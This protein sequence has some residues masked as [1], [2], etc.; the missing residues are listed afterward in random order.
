MGK[1]TTEAQ[2]TQRWGSERQVS[3]LGIWIR[4]FFRNPPCYNKEIRVAEWPLPPVDVIGIKGFAF[5]NGR[6]LI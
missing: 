6:K 3:C 2:G 1:L 4:D 5:S